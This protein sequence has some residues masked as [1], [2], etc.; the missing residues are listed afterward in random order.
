MDKQV[1][2]VLF[3]SRFLI[4]CFLVST[5]GLYSTYN[6][7]LMLIFLIF[8]FYCGYTIANRLDNIKQK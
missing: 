1:K 2:Q 5:L 6:P 4:M 3:K 7:M 8:I